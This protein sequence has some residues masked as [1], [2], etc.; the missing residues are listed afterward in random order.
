MEEIKVLQDNDIAITT[1]RIVWGD[2]VY[3][4]ADIHEWFPVRNDDWKGVAVSIAVGLLGIS[5][6]AAWAAVTALLF[7][8]LGA[9]MWRN[10]KDEIVLKL[11][12]GTERR[13]GIQANRT[14]FDEIV[15]ALIKSDEIV[16]GY[17]QGLKHAEAHGARSEID[18]LPKA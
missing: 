14:R 6:H 9:W 12:D 5:V 15:Q 18:H 7:F 10:R 3:Q 2:D 1:H 16:D 4:F 8:L 11:N 13:L 17:E